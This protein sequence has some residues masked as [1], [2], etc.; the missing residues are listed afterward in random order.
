MAFS[1]F[2]NRLWNNIQEAPTF[3]PTYIEFP[4]DRIDDKDIQDF[5]NID[6][7]R[8][9][10]MV[11]MN[12]MFLSYKRKWHMNFSPMVFSVCSFMYDGQIKE[13][14]YI[15]GPSYLKKYEQRPPEGFVYLNT[16]IVGVHPW[17]GNT[18]SLSVIL[19]R[20][21]ETNNVEKVLKVV[22]NVANSLDFSTGL[23]HYINIG[24]V[25]LDGFESLM[26]LEETTPLL[27]INNNFG[28]AAGNE[29]RPGYYA[30]INDDDS[31]TDKFWVKDNRLYY[32]DSLESAELYQKTEDA[33]D[34]ILFKVG[35]STKRFDEA[36]LSYYESYQSIYNSIKNA[37]DLGEKY[38]KNLSARLRILA[39]DIM[40]SPDLTTNQ[41]K[42][43]WND[44]REEI[45]GFIDELS[46]LSA[47]RADAK[48]PSDPV[49]EIMNQALA[50]LDL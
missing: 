14:P 49:N 16:P 9:Y 6:P 21:R 45:K 48:A 24:N 11:T 26:G 18:M 23:S 34:F 8:H 15:I 20:V 42:L 50:D 29:M 30:L 32:G 27:G 10:F 22:E 12:E 46:K 1:D 4:P 38:R 19:S 35:V 2:I 43:I 31:D 28:Q 37:T 7:N 33:S 17:K 3:V 36:A 41:A 5:E 47:D 40:T 44:K 39:V 13:V 25:V